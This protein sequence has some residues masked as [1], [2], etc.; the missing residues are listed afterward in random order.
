MCIVCVC[1]YICMCI[2]ACVFMYVCMCAPSLPTYP[3]R[4]LASKG[5]NLAAFLSRFAAVPTCNECRNEWVNTRTNK[6]EWMAESMT[7]LASN[8]GND[9]PAAASSAL[10]YVIVV[11]VSIISLS[12]QILYMCKTCI[13]HTYITCLQVRNAKSG[14]ESERCSL[15]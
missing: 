11:A 6:N 10:T 8:G 12:I 2:Y 5:K 14:L 3:V 9:T 4:R 15:F 13:T 7:T 1:I